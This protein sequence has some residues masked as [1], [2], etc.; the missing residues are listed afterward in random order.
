MRIKETRTSTPRGFGGDV[1]SP[2]T[3]TR[4]RDLAEGETMPEGAVE[5]PDKTPTSEWSVQQ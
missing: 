1:G 5:A 3:E 2:V 4:V